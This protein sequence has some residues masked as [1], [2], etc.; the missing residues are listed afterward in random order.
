M[1]VNLSMTSVRK[2]YSASKARPERKK[3]FH[4]RRLVI[5]IT[6]SY[7]QHDSGI[8]LPAVTKW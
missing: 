4:D 5:L 6:N 1:K 7:G 8:Y 3:Y 2:K